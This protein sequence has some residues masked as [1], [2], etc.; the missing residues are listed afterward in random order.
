MV[1]V[2]DVYVCAC[3][4]TE[5]QW[6]EGPAQK[7]R[8]AANMAQLDSAEVQKASKSLSSSSSS[9]K[10]GFGWSLLSWIGSI[11]LNKLQLSVQRV[12]ICLKASRNFC[13]VARSPVPGM[14]LKAG[15]TILSM[16]SSPAALDTIPEQLPKLSS[17]PGMFAYL[18][19][20][21][22]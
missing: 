9:Q 20:H 6:E 1:E 17:Q 21:S 16:M 2:S 10:G 15:Q 8:H 14:S 3:P 7:R 19:V 11:L 5:A 4:W 12:H 13:L 22:A 18:A